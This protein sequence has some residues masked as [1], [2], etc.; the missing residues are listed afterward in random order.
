MS[1]NRD[2]RNDRDRSRV[3]GSQEYEVRYIAEKM[4][5]SE[6]AVR[7][8]IQKVGNIREKVEAYLTDRNNTKE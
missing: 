4:G 1:D 2:L 6:E 7:E 3:A 8:A 5:V